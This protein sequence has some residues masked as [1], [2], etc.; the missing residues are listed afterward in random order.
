[1]QT[2][3]GGD[4]PRSLLVA[5]RLRLRAALCLRAEPLGTATTYAPRQEQEA[6]GGATHGGIHLPGG[7]VAHGPRGLFRGDRRPDS[8]GSFAVVGAADQAAKVFVTQG[9]PA[10]ARIAAERSVLL[11][12]KDHGHG[13]EKASITIDCDRG[14]CLAAGA[15]VTV[16]VR[17]EV[18]LPLTPFGDVLQ[19]HASRLSASASQVVGRYK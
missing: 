1:M 10:S 15:T 4:T 14:S 17:L 12:L 2:S 5:F 8:G 13:L 19:L 9:D 11:A 16:T 6:Q 7:V 3:R 18:S